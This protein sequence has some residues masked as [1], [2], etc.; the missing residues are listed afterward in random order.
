VACDADSDANAGGYGWT[1][2]VND[3]PDNRGQ[4]TPSD[5]P[6]QLEPQ[7]LIRWFGV[8]A[9][10][11]A[12][13]FIC[14]ASGR[15]LSR[16]ARAWGPSVGESGGV[17]CRGN[18]PGPF[19]HGPVCVGRACRV[20]S[21]CLNREFEQGGGPHDN[22]RAGVRLGPRVLPR[23]KRRLPA[24][25]SVSAWSLLGLSQC[26]RRAETIGRENRL[27]E[28]QAAYSRSFY[29]GPAHGE[30]HEHIQTNG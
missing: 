27:T 9:P 5:T 13:L 19:R 4:R 29:F 7:L 8:R 26:S 6:G 21:Q 10:G 12:P 1:R 18:R 2:T 30:N 17:R 14:T 24:R 15:S 20:C 23:T 28:R 3:P 22:R 11:G 16:G 25:G